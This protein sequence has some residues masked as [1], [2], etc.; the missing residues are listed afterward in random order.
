MYGCGSKVTNTDLSLSY[1]D[2]DILV[3]SDIP[4]ETENELMNWFL[5]CL[6]KEICHRD[7]FA[8]VTA[9][10]GTMENVYTECPATLK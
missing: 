10:A 1:G 7:S 2:V 3:L 9:I 6:C 5:S 4:M 8:V